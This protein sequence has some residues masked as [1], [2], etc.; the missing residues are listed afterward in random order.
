MPLNFF[1]SQSLTRTL[2]FLLGRY[3]NSWNSVY[4]RNYYKYVGVQ[5]HEIGEEVELNCKKS[6]SEQSFRTSGIFP[7]NKL[8]L[9]VLI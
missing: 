4:Q 2:P 6:A 9:L 1:T 7:P 3:V 5:V 8:L